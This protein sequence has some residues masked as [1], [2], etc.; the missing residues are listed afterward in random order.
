MNH[1]CLANVAFALLSK[2]QRWAVIQLA[3][4]PEPLATRVTAPGRERKREGEG[5][6]GRVGERGGQGKREG[7]RERGGGEKEGEK[8]LKKVSLSFLQSCVFHSK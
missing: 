2:Q 5:E 1:S 8:S 6:S 7:V 4:E 3:D